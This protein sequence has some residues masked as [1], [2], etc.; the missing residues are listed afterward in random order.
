[1]TNKP[2]GLRIKLTR[3]LAKILIHHSFPGCGKLLRN[4]NK[5]L[6][7]RPKGPFVTT[8]S[9]GFDVIVDPYNNR[10]VDTSI[11]YNGIYEAGT[12][13]TLMQA[14]RKDDIFID[15]GANIGLMSLTA[16]QIVGPTGKVYAFEPVPDV[17]AILKKNVSINNANNIFPVQKALGSKSEQKTIYE[18]AHINKGSATFIKPTSANVAH[19]E[20]MVGTIDDFAKSM[21]ITAVRLIKADVEGWELDV[22]Q[23][24]KHLLSENH[25]PVL[26]V[27]YSGSFSPRKKKLID[28]YD[29]I[30]SVNEYQI[31]KLKHGKETISQLVKIT[32]PADLPQHDNIFCFLPNH[33][34]EIGARLFN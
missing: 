24:A 20:V 29:F 32:K 30:R 33:V 10:G 3:S 8:T 16:S 14:L 28:L 27:E 6:G 18:Q 4:V 5:L 2:N 12:L 21:G 34:K 31:F 15:V 17:F 13:F 19:Q 7:P 23:G 25:A 26:C 9:L 22:L 1:M 11:Y